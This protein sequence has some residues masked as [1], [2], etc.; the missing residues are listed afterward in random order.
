[1][2]WELTVSSKRFAASAN[3]GPIPSPL[4]SEIVYFTNL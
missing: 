3:S 1:L 4:T 2:E